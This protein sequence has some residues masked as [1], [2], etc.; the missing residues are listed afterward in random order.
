MTDRMRLTADNVQA[1]VHACL[2][3]DQEA[4]TVDPSDPKQCIA[5]EAISTKFGFHPARVEE[6]KGNIRSMLRELPEEFADGWSFLN[7]CVTRE[8]NQ[9]GEHRDMECLFALGEAAGFVKMLAP[10]SL[11][12]SLP[13]GMPYYKVAVDGD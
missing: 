7:A 2:F 8:G 1:T 12:S 13:G 6:Q 10:R 9:W 3:S 5:V 4:M 11:W